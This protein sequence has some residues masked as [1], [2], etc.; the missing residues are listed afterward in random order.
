YFGGGSGDRKGGAAGAIAAMILIAVTAWVVYFVSQL[1]V[2]WLSRSREYY[3]DAY[4]AYATRDPG[5]LSSALSKIAY[6]LSLSRDEPSGLRAFYIGDPSTS[7]REVGE[8]M[9][10]RGEFDLD[11][12]GVL[13]E[14]ELEAAMSAEAKSTWSKMNELF[15]T[16]PTT[17]KRII[18]LKGIAREIRTSSFSEEDAYRLV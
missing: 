4:S 16:H 9:R 5:A 17:Y 15:S 12:N 13:D 2:M 8:I 6:G 7:R 10:H 14:R 11:G 18:L 3:A 1:L